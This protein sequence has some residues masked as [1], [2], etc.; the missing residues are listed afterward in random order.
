MSPTTARAASGASLRV[1]PPCRA[2]ST[3]HGSSFASSSRVPSTASPGRSGRIGRRPDRRAHPARQI[4][5]GH[6]VSADATRGN[7][8]APSSWLVA[9]LALE[10]GRRLAG[11]HHNRAG[12]TAATALTHEFCRQL[13]DG[14]GRRCHGLIA[15]G[16]EL[17]L[18]ERWSS[19]PLFHSAAI[20]PDVRC[21]SSTLPAP[22]SPLPQSAILASFLC[23]SACCAV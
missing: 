1:A 8:L 14:S 17:G 3:R 2:R 20:I 16:S 18:G 12:L 7:R 13:H 22:C 6:P 21:A 9:A 11:L 19:T 10:L 5:T 23:A 15:L 4:A